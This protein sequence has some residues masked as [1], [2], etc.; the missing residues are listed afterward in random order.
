MSFSYGIDLATAKALAHVSG[1]HLESGSHTIEEIVIVLVG[2][3]HVGERYGRHWV[4][5]RPFLEFRTT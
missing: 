4:E 5:R 1:V 2:L 3:V